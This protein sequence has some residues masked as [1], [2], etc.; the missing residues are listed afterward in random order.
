MCNGNKGSD[1]ASLAVDG[2]V[3]QLYNPRTDTWRRH[4]E[5]RSDRIAPITRIGEA[6]ER[7]LAFNTPERCEERR[8]LQLLKRYPAEERKAQ[9][10]F[11]P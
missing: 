8:G 7:I 2:T 9:A 6:T 5:I 11:V 10:D 1:I 4:F 3:T